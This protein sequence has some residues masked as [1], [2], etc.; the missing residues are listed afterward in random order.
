MTTDDK[1]TQWQRGVFEPRTSEFSEVNYLY[2][3][4]HLTAT[5]VGPFVTFF[6]S[7]YR[8]L[9]LLVRRE[10]PNEKKKKKK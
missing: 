7:F 3:P 1:S 6:L 8:I 4:G 2:L 9:T 10:L 5:F